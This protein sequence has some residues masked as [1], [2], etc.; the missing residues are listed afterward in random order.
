[1]ISHL[2]SGTGPIL[3]IDVGGSHVKVIT[4][5]DRIKRE[6]ASGPHLSAKTMVKKVKK[7]TDKELVL[8]IEGEETMEF[9]K[10]K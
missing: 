7:L 8:E 1:M 6:F 4:N 5:K 2:A 3:A 9:Q 10:L